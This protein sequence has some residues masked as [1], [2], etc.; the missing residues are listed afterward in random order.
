MRL[1]FT[2]SGKAAYRES[3]PQ[4]PTHCFFQQ[5]HRE[6]LVQKA[7]DGQLFETVVG[8]IRRIPAHHEQRQIGVEA[9]GLARHFKAAEAR[10]GEISDDEADFRVRAGKDFGLVMEIAFEGLQRSTRHKS[11]VAMRFPRVRRLRWDKPAAEAD[12]LENLEK[13]L[14]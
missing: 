7:G 4:Y 12:T 14:G 5:R 10:H 8:G 2:E 11:G 9:R 3:L 13:L 6:G 1:R